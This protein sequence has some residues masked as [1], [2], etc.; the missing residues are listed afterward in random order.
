MLNIEEIKQF[1][2]YDNHEKVVF[3]VDKTVGLR[4]YIAI[5]NTNL[6]PATGGTRIW[7]YKTDEEA[8]KD[9]LN[10]SKAMT[11]KC[12]LAGVKFGGGKAVIISEQKNKNS[13]LLKAYVQEVDKL[14]GEFTTGPD[15]G[16]NESDTKIMSQQSKY[17]LGHSTDGGKRFSTSDMAALGVF[18]G[19]QGVVKELKGVEKLDGIKVAIKGVGKLGGELLRLLI[20]NN[21]NVIVADINKDVENRIKGIYPNIEFVDYKKIHTYPV[22][23]YSPCALG[24]EFNH[25]SIKELKTRIIV[26]GANNQ[27]SSEM[28]GEELYN[29]GI[30]F[31]PDFIVNAGGLINIVD[32]F[33]GGG[34]Q[35]ERVLA[36]IENIKV[37]LKKV[38][39][40]SKLEKLSPNFIAK[41][42]AEDIII[43]K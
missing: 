8:V 27:L 5:H 31:A 40:R 13:E 25:T 34:Y 16:I 22:D 37:I 26:G 2:E 9:V 7:H 12:A 15:I 29:K 23:I 42:I 39:E 38:A 19:I 32:Q 30:F 3:F 24:D 43:N 21:A 18:Y 17:I 14:Q 28:I 20:E 11:Y 36:R 1:S 6:G 41:K 33:E 35:K 4:G 10:L